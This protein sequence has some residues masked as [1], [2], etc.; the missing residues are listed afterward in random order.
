MSKEDGF[1]MISFESIAV[2]SYFRDS[3]E[4]HGKIISQVDRFFKQILNQNINNGRFKFSLLE[5]GS[6][7]GTLASIRQWKENITSDVYLIEDEVVNTN[8]ASTI[9]ANRFKNLSRI[10]NNVL[11]QAKD[12]NTKFIF[13]QESD[14]IIPDNLLSRLLSFTRENQWNHTLAIA[15]V[16]MFNWQGQDL[17]YDTWAFEGSKGEKWGN[18][19]LYKLMCYHEELRPMK[20]I[21]S[22]ALLNAELLIKY[23]ID[24]GEG[25]FPELCK[26]GKSF[27]LNIYCD[28]GSMVKHPSDFYIENR[29]V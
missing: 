9:S 1:K 25:C 28:T 3:N 29:L 17:F 19:D 10:G 6:K 11:N 13:W 7:D 22:C 5:G 23:N 18:P 21:G 15:P 20:S 2:C 12:L 26:Q 8:V 4:W 16:P 24:F 14:L 27:G